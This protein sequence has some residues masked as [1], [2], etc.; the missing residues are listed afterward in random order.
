MTNKTILIFLIVLAAIGKNKA[1]FIGGIVVF[2]FSFLNK[3][4]LLKI[5]KNIFL[6]SGLIL[7]MIWILMPIIQ[8]EKDI[9]YINIRNWF[10][11][12]GLISFLSGIFTVI[13]AA[14]GLE[15]MNTNPSAAIGITMGSIIGVTFFGGIPVGILTGSGITYLIIKLLKKL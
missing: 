12:D 5:N 2:L 7:L 11:I 10:S 1:L 3:E 9:T 13:I 8:N 14:K 4:Y 6:N 15:L